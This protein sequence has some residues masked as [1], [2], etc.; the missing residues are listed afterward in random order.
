VNTPGWAKW[1]LGVNLVV[2]GALGAWALRGP[3]AKVALGDDPAPTTTNTTDL[4]SFLLIMPDTLRGDRVGAKRDGQPVTPNIDALASR[5]TRFTQMYSQAGWTLPALASLLSG[6]FPL[7]VDEATAMKM[8]FMR[9]DAMTMPE[10]LTAAGYNTAV[11]WGPSLLDAAPEFSRGFVHVAHESGTDYEGGVLAWLTEQDRRP[12]FAVVHN[13]DLQFPVVGVPGDPL[14]ATPSPSAERGLEP[15]YADLV[16][17]AGPAAAAASI[18]AAYDATITRYDGAI[19]R[20]VEGL[21]S[22]GL[23][24]D[25]VVVVTSN[26]GVDL[27]EHGHYFHGTTYDT[28]L[29]VPL[30]IADPRAPGGALVDTVVQTIDVMPTV[31]ERAGLTGPAD[32]PG[33]SLMSF[34]GGSGTY[35]ERPVFALCSTALFA[36]RTPT[37]KVARVAPKGNAAAAKTQVFDLRADPTEVGELREPLPAEA[38]ALAAELET[39][40]RARVA[41]SGASPGPAGEDAALKVAL[42]K[43]GY[44]G[45]AT[46]ASV[47]T[48]GKPEAGKDPAFAPPP[49][50]GSG[51][52]GN[53]GKGSAAGEPSGAGNPGAA[54][55]RADGGGPVGPPG[56][57]P[58]PPGKSRGGP[59]SGSV[60]PG[61]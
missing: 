59:Q 9:T 35:L 33:A 19:G 37:Y 7:A 3:T 56:N 39:W 38:T 30:V 45:V 25:T 27:G 16:A 44:W 28:N 1:V 55:Y 11:F 24:D 6:R 61:K 8:A 4:P 15:A 20:M 43:N 17:K 49:S 34:L 51:G 14:Y 52:G 18:S 5:G 29:H 58:P 32:L 21:A 48:G 42:E 46:G 2:F 50:L 54:P 40:W 41:A 10:L 23:T 12:F 57:Y 13:V 36:V 53:A 22:A 60:T 47:G 31:F 26:H